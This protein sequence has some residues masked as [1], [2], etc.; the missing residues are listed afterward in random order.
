M[1]CYV[2][3]ESVPGKVEAKSVNEILLKQKLGRWKEYCLNKSW[4]D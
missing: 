4:I 1:L 3:E 2:I